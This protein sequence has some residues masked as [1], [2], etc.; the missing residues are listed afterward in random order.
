MNKEP[1]TI[2]AVLGVF[3]KPTLTGRVYHIDEDK[4]KIIMDEKIGKFFGE[5]QYPTPPFNNP[6]AYIERFGQI[7]VDENSGILRSYS[8]VKDDVVIKKAGKVLTLHAEIEP[9]EKLKQRIAAG[10]PI[11]FGIRT[12]GIPRVNFDDKDTY[13]HVDCFILSFDLMPENPY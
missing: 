1:E 12:L 4:L 10:V 8:I 3:N 5:M 11:Y 2:S 7:D 6:M 9:S 13:K